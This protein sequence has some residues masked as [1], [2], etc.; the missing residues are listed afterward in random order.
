MY[1]QSDILL[2]QSDTINKCDHFVQ[3]RGKLILAVRNFC[4]AIM[5][6]IP[7]CLTGHHKRDIFQLKQQLVIVCSKQRLHSSFLP[8]KHEE[9]FV[10][11]WGGEV[12]R[13]SNPLVTITQYWETSQSRPSPGK[14]PLS[15]QRFR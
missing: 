8:V 11:V 9:Y 3:V 14:N 4:A 13:S 1:A 5:S 12:L 15:K 6:F 2:C 10:C 7:M